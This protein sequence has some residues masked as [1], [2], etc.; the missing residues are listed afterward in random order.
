[1]K[2]YLITFLYTLILPFNISNQASEIPIFSPPP[3]MSY[4]FKDSTELGIFQYF[5][6][7]ER[8]LETGETNAVLIGYDKINNK[9]QF[10]FSY[11]VG[12]DE[13]FVYIGILGNDCFA[14]VTRNTSVVPI[15]SYRKFESIQ[16]LL[17]TSDGFF[18]DKET[19]STDFSGYGNFGNRLFMK[20]LEMVYFIDESMDTQVYESES[21]IAVESFE[22]SFRGNARINLQSVNHIALTEPGNYFIEIQDYLFYMELN[23]TLK[24]I[25]L[26]IVD[27]MMTD[28]PIVIVSSGEL[29][30]NDESY[31]SGT[32]ILIPGNYALRISGEG[33]YNE[34]YHFVILP[35]VEGIVDGETTK[36]SVTIHSNAT[37]MT[38]NGE[39]Y[40]SSPVTSPGDYLLVLGG[41]NNLTEL[42]GFTILPSVF[43]VENQ[44]IYEQQ[45]TISVNGEAYL[46]GSLMGSKMTISE[47][48]DYMIELYYQDEIVET[49]FFS[50]QHPSDEHSEIPSNDLNN[51]VY[52]IFLGVLALIGLFLIIRKK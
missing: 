48:G 30:I 29:S 43:G 41:Q 15:Y 39:E 21:I 26:G 51:Y 20:H 28:E 8:V 52:F 23:V 1:M 22:L 44:G 7:Y 50:V 14:V 47:S 25:V 36:D 46:N 5:A 2:K 6:G 34:E 12:L 10:V 9:T 24:P 11:D 42:I 4:Y 33:G 32:E 17:F 19:Y 27:E 13:E 31:M 38:L 3:G 49:L 40:L 35:I 16:I 37:W 18:L 45:V